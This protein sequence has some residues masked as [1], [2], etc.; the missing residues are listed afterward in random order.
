MRKKRRPVKLEQGVIVLGVYYT[1]CI[2]TAVL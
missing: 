1:Y 2:D